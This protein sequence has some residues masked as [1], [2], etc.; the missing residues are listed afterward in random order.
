MY[1]YMY[2]YIYIIYI[3][4][5]VIIIITII[6]ITII[7][8]IIILF[9]VISCRGIIARLKLEV[10]LLHFVHFF[11]SVLLVSKFYLQFF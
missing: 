9:V 11:W 2:V 8:I 3:I 6:I 5:I 1:I 4:V 7:I 10:K